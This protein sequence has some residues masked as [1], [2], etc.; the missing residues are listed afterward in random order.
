MMGVMMEVTARLQA[1]RQQQAPANQ[2]TTHHCLKSSRWSQKYIGLG[3]PACVNVLS[4]QQHREQQMQRAWWCRPPDDK[5]ID[6]RR[7]HTKAQTQHGEFVEEHEAVENAGRFWRQNPRVD[8][9]PAL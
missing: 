9:I 7:M 4:L 2:A 1:R 3:L 6:Y 8:A 5:V